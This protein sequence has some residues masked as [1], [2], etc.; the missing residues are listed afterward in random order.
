[1]PR[2]TQDISSYLKATKKGIWRF[3]LKVP[4]GI[5][6]TYGKV[7]ESFSLETT[8]Y[9]AARTKGSQYLIHFK[10]RFAQFANPNLKS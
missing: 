8:N 1:M 9:E 7:E 6:K 10:D 5:Q 4:V 2:K 3:R